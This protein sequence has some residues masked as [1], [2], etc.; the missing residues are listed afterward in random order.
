MIVV[1]FETFV[2]EPLIRTEAVKVMKSF[3]EVSPM[4][5]PIEFACS[6][7]SVASQ[8][9]VLVEG[10]VV[11][12]A[13]EFRQI[14][15]QILKS[16][17]HNNYQTVAR[18]SGFKVLLDAVLD[19]HGKNGFEIK[20]NGRQSENTSQ[21]RAR[22]DRSL[23]DSIILTILYLLDDPKSR[24][25]LRSYIDLRVIFAPFIELDTVNDP[26]TQ[27]RRQN[28]KNAIVCMMRTWT[29]IVLLTS[30]PDCLPKLV[31]LIEFKI[32]EN[33]KLDIIDCIIELFAPLI[34]HI[35]PSLIMRSKES[36]RFYS[37]EQLGGSAHDIPWGKHMQSDLLGFERT[38]SSPSNTPKGTPPKRPS[39]GKTMINAA[40]SALPSGLSRGMESSNSKSTDGTPQKFSLG[41]SSL[42]WD[43]S[44]SS[45][46]STI[47]EKKWGGLR[48]KEMKKTK[49]LTDRRSSYLP[50]ELSGLHVDRLGIRVSL[51][52]AHI[53]D[54]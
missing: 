53:Y 26:R 42:L 32:S 46:A 30:D 9:R 28:A 38:H 48:G 40:K 39:I 35:T 19:P 36:Q 12:E 17:A 22:S 47:D 5:F 45:K 33:V 31:S 54:I 24:A 18:A 21:Q 49:G 34:S 43:I 44:K 25:F 41:I 16:L 51:F 2:S 3:L 13:D 20:D 1:D 4:S 50:S 15:I 37:N 23:A 27:E 11:L 7:V 10:G 14:S 8:G 29:G 6:L 52:Q